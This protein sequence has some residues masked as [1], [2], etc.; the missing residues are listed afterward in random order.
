MNKLTRILTALEHDNPQAAVRL[1]ALAY[2]ELHGLT[3][4]PR[5]QIGN[6]LVSRCG[7]VHRGQRPL[8]SILCRLSKL[9]QPLFDRGCVPV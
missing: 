8:W 3:Q 6:G 5:A 4:P 2:Q 9:M 1:L 7:S